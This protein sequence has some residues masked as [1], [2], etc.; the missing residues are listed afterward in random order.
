MGLLE[1]VIILIKEAIDEA[2]QR[3]RPRRPTPPPEP[4]Q[5]QDDDGE[6]DT[7][8][9]TLARRAMAVR[10]AEEEEERQRAMAQRRAEEERQQALERE[11]QRQRQAQAMRATAHR[12][13]HRIAHLLRQP[14]TLRQVVVLRELLDKPLALRRK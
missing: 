7:L 4:E 3:N 11:R 2:N 9:E 10:R 5:P 13:L 1:E 8:R 14:Q 12:D 6:I